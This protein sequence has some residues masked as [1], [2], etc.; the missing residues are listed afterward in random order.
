M[1]ARAHTTTIVAVIVAYAIAIALIWSVLFRW[2]GLSILAH[3][4]A[5]LMQPTFVAALLIAALVGSVLFWSATP[6]DDLGLSAR[7]L[8]RAVALLL[9]AYVAIQLGLVVAALVSGDGVHAGAALRDPNRVAGSVIAQLFGTAIVEEVTFRGFLLHQLI[10]RARERHPDRRALVIGVAA[11]S[12]LFA[13]V[14]IP[15]HLHLDIEGLYLIPSLSFVWLGGVVASYLYL[16]SGNLAIVIVLHALFNESAP[17]VASPVSP[18]VVLA[19][20]AAGVVVWI[21][22]ARRHDVSSTRAS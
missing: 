9:G 21:E 8:P 20:V 14:H 19:V 10:L 7:D 15:Q 2:S 18:Q 4:S 17:L 1:P 16:R 13:L 3:A 11:S 5:G 12:L 22:R 6:L